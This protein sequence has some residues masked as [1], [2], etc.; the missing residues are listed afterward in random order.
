[1]IYTAGC[2]K[3]GALIIIQYY[4]KTGTA[5]RILE[6]LLMD[7]DDGILHLELLGVR[8]LSLAQYLEKNTIL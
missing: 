1:V 8:T 3:I 2:N 4:V 7:S 6:L 5:Y